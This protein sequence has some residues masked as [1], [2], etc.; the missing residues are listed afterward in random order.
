M[1]NTW[2]NAGKANSLSSRSFCL[3][4]ISTDGGC[5]IQGTAT[6]IGGTMLSHGNEL[7]GTWSFNIPVVIES[8][9]E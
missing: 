5:G 8:S 6:P 4:Y 9:Y 1:D 3:E 7:P 2:P